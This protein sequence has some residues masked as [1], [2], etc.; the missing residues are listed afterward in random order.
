MSD[1]RNI[2]TPQLRE[3]IATF[4]SDIV[5]L[6]QRKTES[7]SRAASIRGELGNQRTRLNNFTQELERRTRP[8]PVPRVSDHALLRYIERVKGVDLDAMRAGI[9]TPE[10]TA[11]I[12]VGATRVKIEGVTFVIEG[13]VIV[14]TFSGGAA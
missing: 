3:S 4:K 11:A 1:L 6:E 13:N 2:P 9:L 5:T 12:Q 14:T 10:I 8:A 7:E